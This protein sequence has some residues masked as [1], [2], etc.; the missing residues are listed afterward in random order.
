MFQQHLD[1]SGK[2]YSVHFRFALKASFWPLIA[3]ITS[4][5]HAILP[6][7]FAFTSQRI[8]TKLIQESEQRRN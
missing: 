6:N 4:F 1:A 7:L 3:A 2:T 5:I 8:V